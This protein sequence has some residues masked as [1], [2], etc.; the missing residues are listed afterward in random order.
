MFNELISLEL[1]S[2]PIWSRTVTDLSRNVGN[3]TGCLRAQFMDGSNLDRCA[4]IEFHFWTLKYLK[5]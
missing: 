1:D 3:D 5:I 2:N 4:L